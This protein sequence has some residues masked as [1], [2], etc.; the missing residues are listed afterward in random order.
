MVF[1]DLYLFPLLLCEIKIPMKLFHTLFQCR[2][3]FP[4]Y[5][6]FCS[7]IEYLDMWLQKHNSVKE[8]SIKKTKHK[9]WKWYFKQFKQENGCLWRMLS[10]AVNMY[11][12]FKGKYTACKCVIWIDFSCMSLQEFLMDVFIFNLLM[13]VFFKKV[14]GINILNKSWYVYTEKLYLCSF[15]LEFNIMYLRPAIYFVNIHTCS[16]WAWLKRWRCNQI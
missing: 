16:S 3:E 12:N 10:S 8:A 11:V 2:Q 15:L 5:W 1:S 4:S 9:L 7:V 13:F 6:Y 14:Y